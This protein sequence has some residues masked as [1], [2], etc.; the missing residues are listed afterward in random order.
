MEHGGMA[1]PEPAEHAR[2]FAEPLKADTVGFDG[3]HTVMRQRG[4]QRINVFAVH[5]CKVSCH[6]INLAL[7]V[8]FAD[9][10]CGVCVGAQSLFSYPWPVHFSSGNLTSK[11]EFRQ[12]LTVWMIRE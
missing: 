6:K 3:K 2:D 11:R 7:F 9:L 4:Q 12:L 5:R 8:H 1:V 10:L